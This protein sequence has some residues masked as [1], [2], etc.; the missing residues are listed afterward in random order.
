[1]SQQ[2][3]RSSLSRR[4]FVAASAAIAGMAVLGRHAAAQTPQASPVSRDIAPFQE[5]LGELL[6]LVPPV[7][8]AEDGQPLA[9]RT[10]VVANVTRVVVVATS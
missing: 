5:R 1:M 9:H 6:A 7:D 3:H 8:G 4:S 10:R 2:S